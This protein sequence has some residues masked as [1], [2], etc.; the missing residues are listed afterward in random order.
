MAGWIWN[1]F[2]NGRVVV[3]KGFLYCAAHRGVSGFGRND[4]SLV[5][6]RVWEETNPTIGAV[7]LR[8]SW[9]TRCLRL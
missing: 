6:E 9:G 3:E 7:R 8:R 4:D 5:G 1:D 2:V